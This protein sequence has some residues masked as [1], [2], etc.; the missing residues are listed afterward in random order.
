MCKHDKQVLNG[1]AQGELSFQSTAPWQYV[2]LSHTGKL[3]RNAQSGQPV[4]KDQIRLAWH[5]TTLVIWSKFRTRQWHLNFGELLKNLLEVQHLPCCRWERGGNG[6]LRSGYRLYSIQSV[7]I[8]GNGI[9]QG[10]GVLLTQTIKTNTPSFYSF[11]K[12]WLWKRHFVFLTVLENGK[13]EWERK[14][15]IPWMKQISETHIKQVLHMVL[16]RNWDSELYELRNATILFSRITK[17][18]Y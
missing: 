8:K 2:P 14:Q 15:L 7:I 9:F 16:T 10:M 1:D 4:R 17:Y 5:D 6:D 11:G 13:A 18:I 3:F 12:W